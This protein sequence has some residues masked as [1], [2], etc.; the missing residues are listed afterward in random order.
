MLT[1]KLNALVFALVSLWILTPGN[2]AA[3]LPDIVLIMADDLG[4]SDIGCYGG[5]I[6]TPHLDRLAGDGVR[7]TQF[8]NTSRCCPSRA[9][10]MTG[11]YSHQVGVGHM[12]HRGEGPAY[13]GQLDEDT[14]TIAERLRES[15]YNTAM[16]GKWHLTLSETI[17]DG[18][19]GS[20]PFQRGFQRFYGTM[21]GAKFYFRPQWLFENERAIT[22]FPEDYFYTKA[23]SQR[24]AEFI[25]GQPP[26]KPLFVY[27]AFYAPHFP[28]QAP[29]EM[30]KMFRGR[31]LAGWDRLRQAR[32]E[33][34]LAAGIIPKGTG[35]SR[36]HK[37]VPAWGSLSP[38]KRDEMDLRMAIYAAQVHMM[39]QGVGRVVDALRDSG[40]IQ[41]TLLLFL[42]DNGAQAGEPLGEGPLATI[43]TPE[44]ELRSTY[45]SGWANLSDTP[46]RLFKGDT[47]EGGVMAPLTVHWPA[48]IRETNTLRHNPAHI[49]DI[50]PTALAA[51]GASAP[52]L[53]GR[54]LLDRMSGVRPLFFEHGGNR[55]VRYGRWKLVKRR[56][57]PSW[58]LYDLERD[59]TEEAD[60]AAKQPQRARQLE[61]LWNAWARRC[62]VLMGPK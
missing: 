31:Y 21:E 62:H 23:I 13:R 16:V 42:S 39:D 46:Y 17:N 4:F 22:E 58:E 50:V 3:G 60:L 41:N 44:A 38:E 55:A 19:N 33:R 61:E 59:R 14:P 24:A 52:E 36:R 9:S 51:A 40:R 37:S 53:E 25:R 48:G 32:H 43:G 28:L 54:D 57:K 27:V 47:L 2:A 29:A 18:P 49:I 20:W 34:Q 8:Y 30:I 12:N 35:L 26:R 56:R 15:G 1:H 7:F 5:E 11:L 6:P 45:G 10:L